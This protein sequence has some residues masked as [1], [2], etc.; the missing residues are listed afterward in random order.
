MKLTTL[1]LAIVGFWLTMSAVSVQAEPFSQ[2]AT[3]IT[4]NDGAASIEKITPLTAK[5]KSIGCPTARPGGDMQLAQSRCSESCPGCYDSRG[6]WWGC[7]VL[8]SHGCIIC[9]GS[10]Q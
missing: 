2:L 7:A 6:T 8:M 4:G 5:D 9:G 10:A 1:T 3:N